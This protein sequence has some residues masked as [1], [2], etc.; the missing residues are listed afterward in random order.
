MTAMDLLIPWPP[1]QYTTAL[2]DFYGIASYV[3]LIICYLI[4][5]HRRPSQRQHSFFEICICWEFKK[6]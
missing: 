5:F 2:I 4:L 1:V 6:Y 3:Y